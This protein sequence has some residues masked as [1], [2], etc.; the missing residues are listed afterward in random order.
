MSKVFNQETFNE[1]H[2]EPRDYGEGDYYVVG[3]QFTDE[4]AAKMIGEWESMLTGEEHIYSANQI[5]DMLMMV[6][7]KNDDGVDDWCVDNW[8]DGPAIAWGK[9]IAQ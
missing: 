1:D 3:L 8:H 4:E 5:T 2:A 9:G 7:N 6:S